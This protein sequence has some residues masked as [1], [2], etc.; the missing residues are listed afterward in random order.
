[1]V[2][3]K[4]KI[5]T[6]V[7]G[8]FKKSIPLS[9][10]TVNGFG[11]EDIHDFRVS[12]KKMRAWLRLL[13][14]EWGEPP[15]LKTPKSVREFYHD[16][17][18]VRNVQVQMEQVQNLC[19]GKPPAGYLGLLQKELDQGKQKMNSSL[20]SDKR[21]DYEK[22]K[23]IRALP[24]KLT[25]KIIADFV[26]QKK[27]AILNIL[28]EEKNDENLH[29]LRKILKDLMYNEKLIEGVVN[30]DAFPITRDMKALTQLL[31]DH[32]DLYMQLHY[33][34]PAYLEKLDEP[35]KNTMKGIC[36]SIQ[37]RK[38]VLKKK[39]LQNLK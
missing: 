21:W 38:D 20:L 16:A 13:N 23:I 10:K 27:G 35:E 11:Q 28:N 14:T 7:A 30:L 26:L 39:I 19:Q 9:K 2:M 29:E 17:G 22:K 34:Q 37:K 5:K 36:N 18:D 33:L 12:I 15:V 31:G 6:Q 4:N 1:M 3:K 32:Q 25:P 24:A 8:H